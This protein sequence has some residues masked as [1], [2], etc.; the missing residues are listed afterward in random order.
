MQGTE[1][2]STLHQLLGERQG[3]FL[4]SL[5]LSVLEIMNNFHPSGLNELIHGKCSEKYLELGGGP[6]MFASSGPSSLR[7]SLRSICDNC[8]FH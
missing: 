3:M 7:S 4:H 5:R 6:K 2:L 1:D 8:L